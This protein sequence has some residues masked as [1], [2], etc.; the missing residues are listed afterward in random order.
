V[1]KLSKDHIKNI[2]SYFL[3]SEDEAR[4]VILRQCDEDIREIISVL[5]NAF[6]S[7]DPIETL[8]VGKD[9]IEYGD[10]LKKLRSEYYVKIALLT[11]EGETN[12]ELERLKKAGNPIFEE[13]LREMSDEES[14]ENDL[15]TA[16]ISHN[17]DEMK[18][19]FLKLDD[20]E[21][22]ELTDEEIRTAITLAERDS[23][24][25]LFTEIDEEEKAIRAPAAAASRA[26]DLDAD[27]PIS[28]RASRNKKMILRF[29][30]AACITGVLFGGAYFVIRDT[31]NTVNTVN[32]E[33]LAKKEN[34]ST[35]PNMA[36]R[37]EKKIDNHSHIEYSE[38]KKIILLD[39]EVLG[40]AGQEKK[41]IVISIKQNG[42]NRHIT[43]LLKEHDLINNEINE[44]IT[45]ET[46]GRAGAGTE[47]EKRR[48]QTDAISFQI[49]SLNKLLETY[50][51]DSQKQVLELNLP[52]I[53]TI[54]SII[55]RWV[56][57]F[58]TLYIHMADDYYPIKATNV[59]L[60]LKPVSDAE[61]IDDLKR[62]E[63]SNQ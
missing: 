1:S 55:K 49:D 48:K 33:Q 43:Y 9:L 57:D 35:V 28:I 16:L 37:V 62:I 42:L 5:E 53:D 41:K 36:D 7:G 32:T 40:F 10:E 11:L 21:K 26:L 47:I 27:N 45:L 51:Y 34:R 44:I 39:E 6:V 50:T 29:A 18:A 14:F 19:L 59:P 38:S 54:K 56:G 3:S 12:N 22:F 61:T 17:R 46:A 52:Q 31:D 58:A 25:K 20:E 30:I 4:A 23:M 8:T 15:N 63:F 60:K 2:R 24:K 13:L